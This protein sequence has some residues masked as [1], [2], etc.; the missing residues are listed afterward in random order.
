MATNGCPGAPLGRAQPRPH[1]PQPVGWPGALARTSLGSCWSQPP[2]GARPVPQPHAS[3]VR[4]S[5]GATK[6]HAGA[7]A[8]GGPTQG[9][10]GHTSS[11]PASRASSGLNPYSH[12]R[13]QHWPGAPGCPGS[14]LWAQVSGV[15]AGSGGSPEGSV[16]KTQRKLAPGSAERKPFC[17]RGKPPELDTT[18]TVPCDSELATHLSR[19]LE[20]PGVPSE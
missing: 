16:E 1:P 13:K 10:P 14:H 20:P 3:R 9:S 6:V 17:P 19:A 15:R 18:H 2:R 12:G 7:R 5:F 11:L 4:I 8:P